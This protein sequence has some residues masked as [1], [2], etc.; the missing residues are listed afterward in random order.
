MFYNRSFVKTGISV[1]ILRLVNWLVSYPRSGNAFLRSLLANYAAESA[2]PLSLEQI[3][4]SACGEHNEAIWLELTGKRPLDRTLAEEMIARPAYIDRVR[5][6]TDP[7]LP[8]IKSHTIH[9]TAEGHATFRFIAGDRVVHIVR[10][11][12]DVVISVAHYYNLDIEAA[13]EQVLRPGNCH[14]GWPDAGFEVTGSWSQHTQGWMNVTGIPVFRTRYIDLVARTAEVLTALVEFLGMPVEKARIDRAVQFSRFSRLQAEER[15]G[16]YI[17]TAATAQD[18]YF[19]DGR[20]GQWLE[21]LTIRQAQRI[22][23]HDP[24]LIDAL[25]F[26]KLVLTEGPTSN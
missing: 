23:D 11:P 18:G 10:H 19:R 9:G 15:N 5:Q 6:R 20:P 4:G 1:R 8:M 12:C 13:V 17:E 2:E 21:R 26:Q 14:H 16:V 22:L 25:G 3:A 24:E 7:R